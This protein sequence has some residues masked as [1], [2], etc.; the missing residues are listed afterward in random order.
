MW[1]FGTWCILPLE[2]TTMSAEWLAISNALAEATEK[3]G[4]FAVAV[5][6]D[7]RGS[8][9]GMIWRPGV[10]VTAEHS[11][12]RDQEIQVTLPG[13]TVASAKL[14]GRDRSTDLAVLKCPEATAA[15]SLGD[16]LSL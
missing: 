4:A 13:G 7:G 11:L 14:A 2:A 9:S 8:S 6:T 3:I 15:A 12:R 10:V 5:H 1:P 16:S